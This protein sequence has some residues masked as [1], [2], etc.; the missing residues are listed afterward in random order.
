MMMSNSERFNRYFPITLSKNTTFE[1]SQN[2]IIDKNNDYESKLQFALKE[3]STNRIA[4]NIIIKE[5][6]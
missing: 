3:S 2:Y 1:A 5:I 4:G 6:N